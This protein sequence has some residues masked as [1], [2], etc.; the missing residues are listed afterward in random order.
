MEPLQLFVN[1]VVCWTVA[2]PDSQLLKYHE[3]GLG[4]SSTS[5]VG[6]N[7][8]EAP[9]NMPKRVTFIDSIPLSSG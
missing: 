5:G 6:V 9:K 2:C 7:H 8:D 1:S 3:D 4:I